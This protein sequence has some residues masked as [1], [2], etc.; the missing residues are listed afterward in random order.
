[1][2][3]GTETG[4]G[5]GWDLE[6]VKVSGTPTRAI[7]RDGDVLGGQVT[8]LLVLPK[9]GIVVSVL[10]NVSYAKTHTMALRIAEAFAD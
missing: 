7:G 8:T 6:T 2:L 5:L 4:H 3:S 1:V 10:S 9:R